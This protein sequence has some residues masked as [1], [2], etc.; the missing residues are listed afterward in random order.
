MIFAELQYAEHYSDMHDELVA[1]V[2]QHFP[3]VRSGHQGDSWIW[4]LD[5]ADK[6]A[7]DTFTS[8]QHQV[9]SASSGPHVQDVI[10]ALRS[11]YRLKV[12]DPP[13]PEGHEDA[14]P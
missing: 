1:F 8:M 4:I 12:Y 3:R 14:L 9:K 6:V 10:D 2:A 11:K 13:D 7:I 5:G